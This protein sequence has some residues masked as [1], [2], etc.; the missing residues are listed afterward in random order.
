MNFVCSLRC[1]VRLPGCGVDTQTFIH[2]WLQM[3]PSWHIRQQ[4]ANMRL[5][6]I[7]L[8]TE[9]RAQAQLTAE[10]S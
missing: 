9:L 10:Q 7:I 5:P 4:F 2:A 8:R 3:S 6:L 1:G